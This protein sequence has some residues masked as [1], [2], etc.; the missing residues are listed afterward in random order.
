MET[1]K[2]D[3]KDDP[4]F[5]IGWAIILLAI[6]AGF[7]FAL[8]AAIVFLVLGAGALYLWSPAAAYMVGGGLA[9]CVG[10]ATLVKLCS[11]PKEK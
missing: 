11:K 9:A 3:R 2:I 1:V 4:W 6:A 7:G 8:I 5:Y 10:I